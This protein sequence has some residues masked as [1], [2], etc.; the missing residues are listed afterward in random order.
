ML[1]GEIA[2]TNSRLERSYDALETGKLG[3]DD[4]APR[5]QQLR[6][7]QEQLQARK[8]ELEALLSDRRVELADLGMVTKCV[9][10]LRSLL[11]ESTLIERRSPPCAIEIALDSSII[12]LLFNGGVVIHRYLPLKEP[13][14]LMRIVEA[15]LVYPDIAS[16]EQ[17]EAVL[18]KARVFLIRSISSGIIL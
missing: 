14:V 9:D 10:D 16:V 11:E 4:L 15:L 17:A 2:G 1:S 7:Q 18:E 5:I 13:V 3:L 12:D 6:Y 8:W